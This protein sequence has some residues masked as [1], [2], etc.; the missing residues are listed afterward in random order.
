M[1]KSCV[2]RRPLHNE[3]GATPECVVADLLGWVHGA[4]RFTVH[5]YGPGSVET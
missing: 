2:R 5:A 4:S 1:M 3:Q